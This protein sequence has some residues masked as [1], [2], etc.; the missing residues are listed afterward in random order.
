M[1]IL[2]TGFEPFAGRAR[3]GSLTLA[4]ALGGK[5]IAGAEVVYECLPVVWDGFSEL[6]QVT[7]RA[8]RPDLFLGMGEGSK[9]YA[10]F[11]WIGKNHTNPE[12]RDNDGKPPAADILEPGGPYLRK[13]TLDF[14]RDWVEGLPIQ[15]ANSENAGNYLCNHLLYSGLGLAKIP[16]GFL[17]LPIQ[18]EADDADYCSTWFPL[19]FRLLSKN[20]RIIEEASR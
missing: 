5:T 16:F 12:A 10:C 1:K 19:L 17:H 8:H 7:L 13:A 9:T 3:N 6:I 18:G 11:E 2:I 4:R 20:V 14:E 15:V